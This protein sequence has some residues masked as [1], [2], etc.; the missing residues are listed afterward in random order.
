MTA[1]YFFCCCLTDCY[2][3]LLVDLL[4]IF[5]C[6]CY[7]LAA[8]GFITESREELELEHAEEGLEASFA[9]GTS[10]KGRRSRGRKKL[11]DFEACFKRFRLRLS[12]GMA[13]LGEEAAG[14][15]ER[16]RVE[17]ERRSKA[18]TQQQQ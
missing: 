7:L 9:Q 16:R 11:Q 4:A 15:E 2:F 5:L 1:C 6:S 3:L 17:Q 18:T 12:E 14:A 8:N 13:A 10:S